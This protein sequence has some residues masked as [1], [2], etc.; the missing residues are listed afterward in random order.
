MAAS[1]GAALVLTSLAPWPAGL[2][3]L[4]IAVGI[5]VGTFAGRYHFAADVVAGSAVAAIVFMVTKCFR[6]F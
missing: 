1:T 6:A 3:F 2:V 5:A 4:A